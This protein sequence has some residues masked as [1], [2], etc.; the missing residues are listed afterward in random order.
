MEKKEISNNLLD[1]VFYGWYKILGKTVYLRKV[2]Y[3]RIGPKEHSFF[4]SFFLHGLNISTVMSY[5]Y[6]KGYGQILPVYVS[7][8]LAFV[9]F[10]AGYF[11]YLKNN[12]ANKIVVLE[13]TMFRSLLYVFIALIY[14]G[15]SVYL[16]WKI[17]DMI[18]YKNI[19]GYS[20]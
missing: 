6:F 5:V 4:I 9:I 15:V 20:G 1:V 12:R 8:V 16:M 19:G 7:L 14:G 17:G 2:N 3:S 18:R 10:L 11:S 13:Y